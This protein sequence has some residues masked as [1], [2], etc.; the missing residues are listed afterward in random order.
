[1]RAHHDRGAHVLDPLPAA[2]DEQHASTLYC[3]KPRSPHKAQ[4]AFTLAVSSYDLRVCMC[5]QSVGNPVQQAWCAF[6][7]RE[8]AG[9]PGTHLEC[10]GSK[11]RSRPTPENACTSSLGPLGAAR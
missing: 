6:S 11:S 1:M 5:D 8:A 9:E 7:W 10:I 4:A 2:T 3:C